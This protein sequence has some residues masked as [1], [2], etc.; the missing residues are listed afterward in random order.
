MMERKRIYGI[1]ILLLFCGVATA[2]VVVKGNVYGGGEYGKVSDSACVTMNGGTVNHTVF[3]GGMGS[4]EDVWAGQVEGNTYVTITGGQVRHSVYGGG[5]LG[6]VG[7][8]NDTIRVTYPVSDPNGNAGKT[9]EIPS[10]CASG[11]GVT[12][13]WISGG[14]IGIDS[15]LMPRET[16]PNLDDYGYVFAGGMGQADSIRNYRALGFAAVDSTYLEISGGL[17]TAS[18][19]GGSE[20]GLVLRNTYVKMTGGQIG[21]GHYIDSENHHQWDGVYTDGQWNPA[22]AAVANGTFT[23]ALA[24]PFHNCDHWDYDPNNYTVYDI[25]ANPTTGNYPNGTSSGGGSTEAKNGHSFFGNLFGGGSGYYPID[26]GVWRRTAG[27]VK[28]NV[29][30]DIQGGHILTCDGTV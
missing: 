1:L 11:R 4:A 27:Q 22:I 30:V 15:A 9:V 10:N 3:G 26:P 6:S 20:N 2:Q 7:Y 12:N 17:V 5:E 18:V 29:T 8:F 16:T 23:D 28:G 13:V 19:Y 24:A 14:Q 21:I 25:N